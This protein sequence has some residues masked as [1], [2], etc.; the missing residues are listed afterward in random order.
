MFAGTEGGHGA[1]AQCTFGNTQM[2][3]VPALQ[4]Q[5]MYGFTDTSAPLLWCAAHATASIEE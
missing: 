1:A 3:E 5:C 2:C 4:S